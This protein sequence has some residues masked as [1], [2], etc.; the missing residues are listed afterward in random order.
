MFDMSKDAEGIADFFACL[1]NLER[2]DSLLFEKLSD[3][4]GLSAVKPGLSKIA[5]DTAKNAKFLEEISASIGNSKIKTKECKRKLSVVCKNTE[6]ILK[7]V[8]DK[9]KISLD[10]FAGFMETLESSEG[11][12]QYLLVQAETFLFMSD[13]I[14]RLYGMEFS[15]FNDLLNEIVQDI[16]VH[17]TLLE[18]I[19]DI[20]SEEQDKGKKAHPV[21]KY[22]RP[23][24]WYPPTSK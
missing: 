5:E 2:K 14:R 15:K 10:D 21:F 13:E 18:D 7:Q 16:G 8:E 17:I 3:K 1:A 24:A 12:D 9:E 23:D 4:I 22:Q 6:Q 20:I 19:K 11:A